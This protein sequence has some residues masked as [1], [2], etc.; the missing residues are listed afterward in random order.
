MFQKKTKVLFLIESMIVGGA[1]R[2][3]VNLVNALPEDEFD[4]TLCS[5]FKESVYEGY[6]ASLKDNI[7]PWIKVETL[8][9]NSTPLKSRFWNFL[10]H[11]L[12][13]RLIHR[14]FIGSDYDCEVA[15][16][17]GRPTRLLSMSSNRKSRKIAWLHTT[18]DLSIPVGTVLDGVKNIYDR[19]DCV[20]AVSDVVRDSF[21]YRT[22]YGK[23]ISVVRNLMDYKRIMETANDKLPES[24]LKKRLTF[25]SVGRLSNVKG[26]DRLIS[27]S[28]ILKNEGY[29]FA[30]NIVG[31][32]SEFDSLD[33]AIR[34]NGLEDTVRLIGHQQ[35]PYSCIAAADCY[36]C[37]SR[38]EGYPL[39]INEALIL[40]KPIVSVDIPAIQ[41][42]VGE[43][44][45]AVVTGENSTAGLYEAMKTVLDDEAL[46]SA[47][48]A[49]AS[50]YGSEVSMKIQLEKAKNVLCG[51]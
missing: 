46:F 37:S 39:S 27:A 41:E 5:V 2:A 22:E 45:N 51:I 40:G 19:F 15:F 32:G 1:E 44:K 9:D 11:R 23:E 25:V 10:L 30:V 38:T 12:P 16:Y 6:K 13:D 14:I 17:E 18:T 24:F 29:D 50:A 49:S 7:A 47:A 8:F 21:I 3:L 4:V 26:Y 20:V 35:N 42:V 34:A 48:Q 33:S 43:F 31:G 28:G 36:V